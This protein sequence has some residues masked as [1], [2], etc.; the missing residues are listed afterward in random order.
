LGGL[1]D[2]EVLMQCEDEPVA[3]FSAADALPEGRWGG[4][5]LRMVG[6]AKSS[7]P[8]DIPEGIEAHLPIG[9]MPSQLAIDLRALTAL[10]EARLDAWAEANY[11]ARE[12][13]R[14]LLRELWLYGLPFGPRVTADL[15][16]PGPFAHDQAAERFGRDMP[17]H[18][19]LESVAARL[20]L[21]IRAAQDAEGRTALALRRWVATLVASLPD[22]TEIPPECD[23]LLEPDALP[24]IS[25]YKMTA[26]ALAKLPADRAERILRR[27]AARFEA[28]PPPDEE[29]TMSNTPYRELRFFRTHLS[30]AYV[31]RVASL[32]L[33]Y[34][35]DS[36]MWSTV[37]HNPI[38]FR[39]EGMRIGEAI[40]RAVAGQSVPETLLTEIEHRLG[41]DVAERVRAV[42]GRAESVLDEM[43]R[44]AGELPGPKTPIYLLR[45]TEDPATEASPA[46]TG[47]RPRG[48]AEVDVP[49]ARGRR[50]VHAVTVDLDVVPELAG[51]YPGA[52]T[53]SVFVQAY[54]ET[55]TRAQALVGRTA[56]ELGA[57]P[58]DLAHARHVDIER[59]EVPTAIFDAGDDQDPRDEATRHLASLV[60]REAGYLL[61]GPLW[62]QSGPPGVDP[63]FIAQLD[64]RLASEANFGDCGIAY[65][66]EHECVWQCH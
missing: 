30:D 8:S 17:Y 44:I 26:R 38:P 31:D 25:Y 52:R 42:A 28:P 4:Q 65:C 33:R 46:S 23:A 36:M 40:A 5:A 16:A 63:R 45:P 11:G 21:V 14:D 1:Q 56:A 43:R 24:H 27:G 53:L 32:L 62:L 10:G 12:D 49:R 54:S 13:A 7:S 41:K 18:R 58:G 19:E 15:L 2:I 57:A 39:R 20:P 35:A 55:M 22:G 29:P 50:L 61:G 37:N 66:F 60:Y 3:F 47:G 64:E 9:G 6:M 48:F 34:Q 59:I 51:D